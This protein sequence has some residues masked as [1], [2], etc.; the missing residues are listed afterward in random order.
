MRST[1]KNFGGKLW[2]RIPFSSGR[3]KAEDIK[4][5]PSVRDGPTPA[6]V[7]KVLELELAEEGVRC[8]RLEE[9]LQRVTGQ[10]RSGSVR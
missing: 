1:S 9:E 3:G 8:A 6:P 10:G 4:L 2:S 5:T 7:T